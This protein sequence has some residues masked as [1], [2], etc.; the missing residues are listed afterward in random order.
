MWFVDGILIVDVID[1]FYMFMV[2]E[3]G[4]CICVVVMYVDLGNMCE[5]FIIEEIEVVEVLFVN[6][7]GVII[8]LG[9]IMV[10]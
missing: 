3:V 9:F 1:V 5:G 7:E 10:G 6:F 4:I 8:V 2:N